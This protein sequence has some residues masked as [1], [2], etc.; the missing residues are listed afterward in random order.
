L[1]GECASAEQQDQIQTIRSCSEALLGLINTILDSAKIDTG[2]LG[3]ENA[4]F[5]LHALLNDALTVVRS[6]AEARGLKVRRM[7]DAPAA[8]VLV[9]DRQRIQQVILNLLSNAIK[10]TERG[11]VVLSVAVGK[12]NPADVRFSVRDSGIGIQKEAQERIFQPF[13]QADSSTTRVY[14]GTGLGLSISAALVNL[15]GGELSV[16]SEPG[17]GSTFH[18]S[19][20]LPIFPGLLPARESESYF[21]GAQRPLR[22]L[23]AEDNVVNQKLA[24]KLLGK[25]GHS[26]EVAADGKETLAAL[27]QS[28]FDVILMDC[29]MPVM[30]GYAATRAIRALESGRRIP[31]VAVTANALAEDQRK[32]MEAGM[33]FFLT[34]PI[35]TKKLYDLLEEIGSGKAERDLA[36][37]EA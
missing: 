28:E 10:F 20:R 3:L 15:M 2:K 16:D 27:G 25:M 30:D 8:I 33:D 34:K 4:P 23:L 24:V 21:A 35:V 19:V 32:C 22:V 36:D 5:S 7:I 13:I 17:K 26:V 14:G 29:Q 6:P 31:I 11:E 37:V 18:F 1:S 9:G 12:S